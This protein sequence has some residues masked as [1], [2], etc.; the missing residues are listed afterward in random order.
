M[1]DYRRLALSVSLLV[2]IIVVCYAL[3]MLPYFWVRNRRVVGAQ[4]IPSTGVLGVVEAMV[5]ENQNIF[6]LKQP[7]VD[8]IKASYPVIKEVRLSSAA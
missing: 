8:R 7:I 3:F 5:P 1:V 4:T 6:L 2:L